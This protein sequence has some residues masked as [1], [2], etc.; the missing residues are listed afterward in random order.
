MALAGVVYG[1]LVVTGGLSIGGSVSLPTGTVNNDNVATAAAIAA[2][3]CQREAMIP[4]SRAGTAVTE[5]LIAH[6]VKGTTATLKY[7]TASN[8]TACA[9]SSTVT[10]DLQ[11]NGV[12]VLSA[13]LTLNAATGTRGE[14]QATIST[15]ALVDGDVLEVVITATQSGADALATGV[16]AQ[17]DLDEAYLV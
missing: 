7:F 11:K 2:S 5:T 1:D 4:V 9:G 10:V 14:A 3:K 17:I 6:V 12:S 16:Y 8:V 15:P 13:V